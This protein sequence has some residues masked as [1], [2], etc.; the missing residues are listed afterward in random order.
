MQTLSE[1]VQ[2]VAGVNKPF[3]NSPVIPSSIVIVLMMVWTI[4]YIVITMVVLTGS[5]SVP[6]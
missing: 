4:S 3:Y 2:L 6:D 5:V 1:K